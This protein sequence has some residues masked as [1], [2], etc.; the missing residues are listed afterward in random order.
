MYGTPVPHQIPGLVEGQK[1]G[2]AF[3]F[4]LQIAPFDRRGLA[5][6]SFCLD[7]GVPCA[8]FGPSLVDGHGE[9]LEGESR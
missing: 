4:S 5:T 3:P 6:S 1:Y 8:P 2:L 7:H 9:V